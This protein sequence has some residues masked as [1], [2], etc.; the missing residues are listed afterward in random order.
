VNHGHSIDAEWLMEKKDWRQSMRKE[1]AAAADPAGSPNARS[2][3]NPI[4]G[5]SPTGAGSDDANMYQPE[6]DEMRCLL[7]AH[8]GSFPVVFAFAF[9]L[10]F[11]WVLFRERGSGE[12]SKPPLRK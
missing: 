8:G 5:L 6:M 2:A 10:M 9:T 12:V 11:R 4:D 3:A 1:S 7:W